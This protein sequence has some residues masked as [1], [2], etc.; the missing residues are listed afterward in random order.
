MNYGSYSLDNDEVK[1]KL[2][3]TFSGTLCI[4]SGSNPYSHDSC[5]AR[6]S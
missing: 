2:I 6:A 5:W 1:K 4:A 3:K